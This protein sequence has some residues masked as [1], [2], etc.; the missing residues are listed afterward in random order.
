MGHPLLGQRTCL[1]VCSPDAPLVVVF[2]HGML[3][4]ADQG[5]RRVSFPQ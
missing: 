5:R 3:K 4:H 1:R 2:D